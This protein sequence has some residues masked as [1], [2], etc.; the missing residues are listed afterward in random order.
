[1]DWASTTGGILVVLTGSVD[2]GDQIK[3]FVILKLLAS[4]GRVR[5]L[6]KMELSVLA[7]RDIDKGC[8]SLT[9]KSDG[10]LIR[11]LLAGHVFELRE[12]TGC[13]PAVKA[14]AVQIGGAV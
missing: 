1:M 3:A 2:V 14:A 7:V 11:P 10:H 8:S 13:S 6:N 4:E 12:E 5:Q 9:T